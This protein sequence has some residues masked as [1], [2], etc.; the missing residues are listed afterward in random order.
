MLGGLAGGF[1]EWVAGYTARAGP[2]RGVE[3]ALLKAG[4]VPW[5]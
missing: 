1:S 4:T 3:N 5:P 2:F